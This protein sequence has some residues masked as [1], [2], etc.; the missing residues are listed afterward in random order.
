MDYALVHQTITK[1][2]NEV[3]I[4]TKLPDFP[5]LHQYNGK[6]LFHYI[7]KEKMRFLKS[8]AANDFEVAEKENG[9]PLLVEYPTKSCNESDGLPKFVRDYVKLKIKQAPFLSIN[10]IH[11]KCLEE[12]PPYEEDLNVGSLYISYRNLYKL[13]LLCS[14]CDKIYKLKKP[15]KTDK[16][17]NKIFMNIKELTKRFEKDILIPIINDNETIEEEDKKISACF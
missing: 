5:H 3:G 6:K 14:V 16:T 17:T 2:V 4:K 10:E 12:H 9:D 8:A 15:I 7:R 11:S 13:D 1:S